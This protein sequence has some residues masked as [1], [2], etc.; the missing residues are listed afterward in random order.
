M[1]RYGLTPFAYTM[2]FC[3]VLLSFITEDVMR[4]ERDNHGE[5]LKIKIKKKGQERGMNTGMQTIE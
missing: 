4:M 3:S 5:I 2:K 1:L